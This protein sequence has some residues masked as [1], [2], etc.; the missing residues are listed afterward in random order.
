MAGTKAGSQ[1][2]VVTVKAKYGEDFFVRQGAKGG[3]TPTTKLKGFAANRELAS[4]AGARGGS[5]SRR[6]PD[7]PKPVVAVTVDDPSLLQRIK[8]QITKEA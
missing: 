2:A 8:L 3:S 6:G 4:V 1:K 7:K 5:V